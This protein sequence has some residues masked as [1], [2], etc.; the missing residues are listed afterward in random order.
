VLV[1]FVEENGLPRGWSD[2]STKFKVRK[3]YI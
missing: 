2:L 1:G 3:Y